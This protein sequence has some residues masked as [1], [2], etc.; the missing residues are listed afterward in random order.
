MTCDTESTVTVSIADPKHHSDVEQ[1]PLERWQS[2]PVGEL[3]R[4]LYG[5]ADRYNGDLE[6]ARRACQPTLDVLSSR[7]DVSALDVHR[8][9]SL[10]KRVGDFPA[11]RRWFARITDHDHQSDAVGAKYFHLGEMLVKE[12]DLPAALAHFRTCLEH[13]PGHGKAREYAQSLAR[14][15]AESAS[16][17]DS[18]AVLPATHIERMRATWNSAAV[19]SKFGFIS[20]LQPGA[21]WDMEEFALVGHRFV[22]HMIERFEQYGSR[23]LETSALLEIGCGVGRF[24]R[25]LSQR[26]ARV[27]GVDIST[28]MLEVAAVYCAGLENVS[29]SVTDG[30]S[31][32]GIPDEAFDYM[33]TAGVLQ[34]ITHFDVIASYLREAI[35]ALRP[36]GV[37]LF[38]FEG[39]RTNS[40]G[41]GQVGAKITA[42]GLDV[43]LEGFNYDICEI[44]RDPRDPIGNIVIVLRKRHSDS[45]CLERP[46]FVTTPLS[47]RVWS[48][49]AYEGIATRTHHHLR[50][51]QGIRPITFFDVESTDA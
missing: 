11:A 22:E 27:H 49:D 32:S 12:N 50:V 5:L 2:C 14:A 7:I 30:T 25:P 24:M 42:C 17:K 13:V 43:A 16:A 9:G 36:G 37:F 23:P 51:N 47:T 21:Q 39:N 1:A 46:S 45:T 40:L 18:I 44:T 35:R 48:S 8:I 26:F 33:V 31:L 15:T 6:A 28:N 19:K 3:V 10:C 29:T 20:H 41:S 38:Q 4:E 34:H